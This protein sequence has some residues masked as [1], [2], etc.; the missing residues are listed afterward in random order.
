MGNC[1][2]GV[3]LTQ[4]TTHRDRRGFFRE[5]LRVTDAQQAGG[6]GQWSHSLMYAGVTKAWHWH[7]KQTDWW[8]VCT[9]VLRVGLYDGR[10]ESATYR[11]TMDFLMGD[12]QD[13]IRIE[14]PPGVVHGCQTVQGP[15]NLFYLT[16]HIYD[17]EDELRIPYDDPFI[18]F[19]WD[20]AAPVK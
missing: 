17:P 6:M 2:D 4:L 14:V 10:E 11:M 16:S 1:I 3:K 8:Y 9:G 7:R 5:I 15:V 18:P 12:N 19:D 13:V 20:S